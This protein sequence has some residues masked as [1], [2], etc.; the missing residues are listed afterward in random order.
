MPIVVGN[1]G[2]PAPPKKKGPQADEGD[3]AS[4]SCSTDG[5]HLFVYVG[6]GD[7][8]CYDFEGN[9][10]WKFN[11][12]T[13]Y[14]NYSIQH[15]IHVTPLLHEDRLYFPLLANGVKHIVV[16]LDKA[17]GKEIWKVNRPT[18]AKSE[19]L[20]AYTSPVLWK[21]G[22]ELNLVILGSDFCTGHSLKDGTELWRL[23]DINL[24]GVGNH[25][26]IA[27]PTAS[28]DLLL[29]PTCRGQLVF[30]LK[31]GVSGFVKTGSPPVM[32]RIDDGAPDVSTALI[33][34]GLVYLPQSSSNLLVVD[35]KTGAT[36]YDVSLTKG[37]YRASPVFADGHIYLQGR[38]SGDVAVIKP[39]RKLEKIA[40]NHLPDY[41]T[42]SPAI[43][44]GRIYLR[45]FKTLYAISEGGK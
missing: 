6:T 42:A 36:Q 2:Q 25:R 40:N 44:N 32:W 8:A 10:L 15:G 31:P 20:E 17:T 11:T 24:R 39:G 22:Q 37:R 34:D 43:S 30:G 4:P 28:D 35:A 23:G 16:A 3:K 21:N 45:G 13:R 7:M 9:Q 12:K 27:T 26:I 38:D 1:P 14:G 18:T 29:V 5:K 19:S 33:H 41:F